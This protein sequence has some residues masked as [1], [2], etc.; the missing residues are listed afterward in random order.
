M[1]KFYVTS[2][3]LGKESKLGDSVSGAFDGRG[4]MGFGGGMRKRLGAMRGGN[5][6][7]V[8]MLDTAPRADRTKLR[9]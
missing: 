8:D 1:A 4:C 3:A 6:K 9:S 5:A 7:S 2:A